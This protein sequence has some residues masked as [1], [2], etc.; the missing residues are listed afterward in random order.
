M[1]ANA[2][3]QWRGVLKGLPTSELF[4]LRDQVKEVV[5]LP[6][7]ERIIAYIAAGHGAVLKSL[8]EGPVHDHATQS[9]IIGYL[10]G[11]AE[12]P[13]VVQAIFDAAS[14]RER[15]VQKAAVADQAARQEGSL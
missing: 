7:W 5:E 11:L 9:H 6:G 13:T 2:T 4:A 8:T 10:K 1:D 12:A 3:G 15:Q 14:S